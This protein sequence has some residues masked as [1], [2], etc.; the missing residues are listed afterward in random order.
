V[1]MCMHFCV[2]VCVSADAL[3][4]LAMCDHCVCVCE[5]VYNVCMCAFVYVCVCVC[6][7]VCS[8]VCGF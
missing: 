5:C 3:R 4:L 8:F 1:G 7:C 2:Y 6:V